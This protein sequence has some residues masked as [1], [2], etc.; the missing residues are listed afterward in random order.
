MTGTGEPLVRASASTPVVAPAALLA[1]GR[2]IE[3]ADATARI[4]EAHLPLVR[5]DIGLGDAD[6]AR[7]LM[8]ACAADPATDAALAPSTP[9]PSSPPPAGPAPLTLDHALDLLTADRAH[10]A[11]IAHALVEA[12]ESARV[13]R[14]AIPF[15]LYELLVATRARLPRKVVGPRLGDFLTWVRERSALAVGVIESSV[16]RDGAYELISLGRHLERAVATSRL[17]AA[18][19]DDDEQSP[20][21]MSVLRS[22]GAHEPHVRAHRGAATA[23]AAIALLVLDERFPRSV[24]HALARAEGLLAALSAL[25]VAPGPGVGPRATVA[26]ATGSL[27]NARAFVAALSELSPPSEPSEPVAASRAARSAALRRLHTAVS[28]AVRGVELAVH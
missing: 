10:P 23:A 12:R 16:A 22:A 5:D 21:W 15:E 24:A 8:A 26:D 20:G 7:L 25:E 6:A 3:R 14:E 11:S 4:I 17:L 13:A 19:A 1:L 18:H 27:S 2:A 9:P 28:T